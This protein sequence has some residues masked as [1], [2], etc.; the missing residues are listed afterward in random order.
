MDETENELSDQ[1][2]TEAR[3]RIKQS[4]KLNSQ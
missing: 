3:D 2:T 4:L 1:L